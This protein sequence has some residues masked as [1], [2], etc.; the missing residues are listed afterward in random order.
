M[1]KRCRKAKAL[2]VFEPPVR[3]G[4]AVAMRCAGA[5]DDVKA[6]RSGC[7]LFSGLRPDEVQLC[8]S[9]LLEDGLE[10]E[11]RLGK[12]TASGRLLAVRTESIT[13]ASG[14]GD[15]LTA[16]LLHMWPKNR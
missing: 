8:T 9:N 11:A 1:A 13:D 5:A 6:Y 14:A 3:H 15:W 10:D 2:A 16:G 12:R 4:S 7:A